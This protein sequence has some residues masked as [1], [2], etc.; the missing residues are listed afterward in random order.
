[1]T[2][3]CNLIRYSVLRNI[4]KIPKRSLSTINSNQENTTNN[5][6]IVKKSE[7]AKAFEKHSKILQENETPPDSTTFASLLRNS[8]FIDV[9]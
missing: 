2:Q 5:V 1:M 4:Y 6:E 7:F 8:K 3:I 9:I